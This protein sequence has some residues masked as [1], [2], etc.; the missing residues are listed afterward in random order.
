MTTYRLELTLTEQLDLCEALR[1][2]VD[3]LDGQIRSGNAT[4]PRIVQDRADFIRLLERVGNLPALESSTAPAAT[5]PGSSF[6]GAAG[7]AGGAQ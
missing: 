6:D 7:A 3:Y 1:C 2:H 4:H 5:M